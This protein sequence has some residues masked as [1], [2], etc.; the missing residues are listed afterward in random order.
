MSQFL[1]QNAID[2]IEFEL[3]QVSIKKE[4]A[5]IATEKVKDMYFKVIGQFCVHQL[6]SLDSIG[7]AISDIESLIR[8]NNKYYPSFLMLKRSY[9]N[10]VK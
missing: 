9:Q 1:D 5:L 4:F 7:S 3:A 2:L 8:P 6:D 10:R